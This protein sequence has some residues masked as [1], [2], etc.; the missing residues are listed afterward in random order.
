MSRSA[1]SMLRTA[2]ARVCWRRRR[3]RRSV[4][5]SAAVHCRIKP[6]G[7]GGEWGVA[8]RW[9]VRHICSCEGAMPVEGSGHTS[10]NTSARSGTVPSRVAAVA[11]DWWLW[12]SAALA[13][14]QCLPMPPNASRNC[15]WRHHC[16]GGQCTAATDHRSA[17]VGPPARS[18]P[19]SEPASV[20]IYRAAAQP[21]S[22]AASVCHKRSVQLYRS[23][24]LIRVAA[25][26]N[27]A[28][29]AEHVAHG[30]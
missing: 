5:R 8:E 26:R 6:R 11:T 18:L 4:L 16:A 12:R 27:K 10:H 20:R 21:L 7:G 15:A 1:L 30:L 22:G 23:I 13:C 25:K 14:S 24:T 17:P 28:Q 3:T 19:A 2:C 9:G 29:Q